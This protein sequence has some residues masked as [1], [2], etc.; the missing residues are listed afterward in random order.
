MNNTAGTAVDN[1]LGKA[2]TGVSILLI[3]FSLYT[4]A[5]GIFPDIIQRG[6]HLSLAI[7]LVYLQASISRSGHIQAINRVV[8]LLLGVVAFSVTGY[9]VVF[10]DAVV[11]RYGAITDLEIIIAAVA[12]V[13]LLDATRRTIGWSMLVLALVFLAYAFWGNVLPGD[14][15]HRGYDLKRV[16]SQVYLGA[17]G[18]FGTPL[19]VSATFV[20]LIVILGALLEA[21]GASK[22]LMDVAVAMTGRSRGGPAKAAVVGS[23]LMGMISGTAVANVLTTGTISIPLMK[24]GG[25]RGHV[26]AAIEAVASTGGQLMPPI[27]GAA[28]F[29]MADIIETPYAEIAKSAIIPAALFYIAVFAAVHLEAVKTGLKPLAQSELPSARQALL[30]RGHVLLAIPAF[31]GFIVNGYSVMYASLWAICTLLVLSLLRG[32]TRM[33]AGA[34]AKACV[35][36]TH[37]VLPVAMATATAGIIIAVVTLTGVGLKFSSLIVTLS[38]GNLVVALMLTMATSLILGMG[39]PTAAAYILVATLAAPALVNMG[40]NILAAHMFVF[41]SA[42][43]SAITP[44][45]A[46][47]A[48]A[49]AALSG[50]N[51]MRIAL[52]AVKYGL[53]AFLIPYFFVFDVRLLGIGDFSSLVIPVSTAALGAVAL[54]G[55]LQGWFADHAPWPLRALLLAGAVMLIAPGTYSDIAGLLAIA[56]VIAIQMLARSNSGKKEKTQLDVGS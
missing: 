10:Y 29:L 52:T 44:P 48:F 51:P 40:V 53:V 30:E 50:E 6:V 55:A 49:A 27:M 11:S 22:V 47:A 17:D 42:M 16:L 7:V 1:Q 38:G 34:L 45:V 54:A 12:V 32:A 4:A 9:Q 36:A 37:A 15:A 18:I 33:G 3:A 26:A 31:V 2:V 28:A 13:L 21:S 14:L 43:L 24:R 41:Y 56:T 35:A 8:A 5:F 23:S 20:I 39:L 46:L 25:Y 19:G